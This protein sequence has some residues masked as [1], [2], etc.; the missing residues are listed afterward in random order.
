MA[1][2]KRTPLYSVY[3]KYGAKTVDFGGWEM[4]VQ[5]SG[6]KSEHEAVRTKAGLF[7]V[8]H[9]GEAIVEGPEAADFLQYMLTNNIKN[10]EPGKALYTAMCYE[11]GGTVDDLL[12]YQLEEEKYMLVLNAANIE[13]DLEWLRRHGT[14]NVSITDI[15]ERTALI[16]VQGPEAE[17]ILQK[18]TDASLSEIL[19]F[20]FAASASIGETG[21]VL[22]SRTGYTGEDG[23]ELYCRSGDALYCWETIMEAGKS[24]GIVPCGLG[25]RDTLR[26]EAKLPLYG[27]ELSADITPL[28]AGIGFCVKLKQEND[29]IGK[30]ALKE[31][32]EAGLKRKLVG[33][34]MVD[35]AIPRPGYG[36]RN[37]DGAEIGWITTGT[38]SPTLK[39]N[40]G[41]ALLNAEWSN[42]DQAV[43]VDVRGKAKRAKVA[44][45][46]FYKRKK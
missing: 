14:E 30:E 24:R 10:L 20:R 43:A 42:L 46:P 31:Q 34:E 18:V 7:D 9:M 29:F 32:K 17:T 3:E 13:K 25:A 26:F 33:I 21:N 16:A 41:L 15:S 39:K 12:V 22:I 4:A 35:K 11:N 6:I 28:E 5:F 19:P 2:L 38:Q 40:V 27:Q 37:D 23:F 36:V 1:E 44:A 8:S 45:V